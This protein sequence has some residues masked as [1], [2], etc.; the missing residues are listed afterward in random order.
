VLCSAHPTPSLSPSI[1]SLTTSHH[2]Q[3]PA[4]A[5]SRRPG[6]QLWRRRTD[7]AAPFPKRDTDRA[8]QGKEAAPSPLSLLS[9]LLLTGSSAGSIPTLIPHGGSIWIRPGSARSRKT[10]AIKLPRLTRKK[11]TNLDWLQSFFKKK[12]KRREP[13]AAAD[14]GSDGSAAAAAGVAGLLA[15]LLQRRAG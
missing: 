2:R 13:S 4:S 11:I 14:L 1:V 7:T 12:K 10:P 15:V 9:S 8:A 6:P 5:S 3:L